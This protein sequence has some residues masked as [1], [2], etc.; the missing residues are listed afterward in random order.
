M[1]KPTSKKPKKLEKP[2]PAPKIETQYLSR[3]ELTETF[4]DHVEKFLFDGNTLR[5]E[6]SVQR[7]NVPAAKDRPAGVRVPVARMVLTPKAAVDLY[8]KL[9]SMIEVLQKKGVLQ[10]SGP[11]AKPN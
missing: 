11:T 4:S 10:K 7:L 6:F 2:M 9:N 8:N 3:N 5:V 1:R